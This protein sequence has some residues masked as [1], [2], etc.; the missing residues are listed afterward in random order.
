MKKIFLLSLVFVSLHALAIPSLPPV[1]RF[2]P[3]AWMKFSCFGVTSPRYASPT[4]ERPIVV[5]HVKFNGNASYPSFENIRDQNSSWFKN[6]TKVCTERRRARVEFG[7]FT[8]SW[9][10]WGTDWGYSRLELS[11]IAYNISNQNNCRSVGSPCER[12][13]QCCGF[14]QYATSCNVSLNTCESTIADSNTNNQPSSL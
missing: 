11:E 9:L 8:G 3:E 5:G 12:P 1:S 10:G 2:I 14:A 6:F 4:V 13:S 7:S